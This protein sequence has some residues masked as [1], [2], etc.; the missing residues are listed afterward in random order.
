MLDWGMD[1]FKVGESLGIGSIGMWYDNNV[2]TVS[3]TDSVICIISTNGPIRS[4]VYTK[5]FGW[6]IGKEKYNLFSNL[7]ISAGSRLTKV[8]LD[9]TGGE[10]TFC[11]GLAK[12][13]NCEFIKSN[14]NSSGWDYIVLYGKQSLAGDNLGIAI[15]YKNSDLVKNT[16]DKDSYVV[17]LKPT[18]GKLQYYFA[19]AWE[20]EPN[21]IKNKDQFQKYLNKTVEDLDNPVEVTIE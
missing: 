7:S 21:G 10:A 15:F 20:E 11:T 4:D 5:Y 14:E 8:D 12:H 13:D 17:V 18:N 16:D 2:Y 9:L 1:I 3:K 19:A 6:Q